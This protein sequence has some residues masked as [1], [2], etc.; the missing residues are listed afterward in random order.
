M[1]IGRKSF[2]KRFFYEKTIFS[3]VYRPF[4][5]FLLFFN[6]FSPC[7]HFLAHFSQKLSE[8]GRN[9]RKIFSSKYF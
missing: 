8:I 7:A 3:R 2:F 4:F 1:E 9:A 6:A 5:N